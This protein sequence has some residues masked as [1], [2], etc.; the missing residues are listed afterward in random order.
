MRREIQLLR[1]SLHVC[2]GKWNK[3]IKNTIRENV[4]LK[5]QNER[6]R[7]KII[8][9]RQRKD[10]ADGGMEAQWRQRE[11]HFNDLCTRC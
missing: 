7:K 3:I 4:E 8:E 11:K 9:E 2:E 6:L 10:C 1:E 5:T